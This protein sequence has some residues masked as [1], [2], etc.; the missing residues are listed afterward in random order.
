MSDDAPRD[1]E[2]ATNTQAPGK[3]RRPMS[4]RAFWIWVTLLTL[5]FSIGACSF[6]VLS[7][8]QSRVRLG[9]TIS[10]AVQIIAALKT[11]NEQ[12]KGEWPETLERA[13]LVA[14]ENLDEGTLLRL[15]V[16]PI[17][18]GNSKE[19]IY[20]R[21]ANGMPPDQTAIIISPYFGEHDP[22]FSGKRVVGFAD[23]TVKAMRPEAEVLLPT[24]KKAKLSDIR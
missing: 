24:G 23:S 15:R 2:D 5:L 16:P 1:P 14:F 20:L 7:Q 12:A 17:T 10:N 21:P 3:Q 13:M 9:W 11:G 8:I 22:Y 19:W 4:R 18:G 6:T